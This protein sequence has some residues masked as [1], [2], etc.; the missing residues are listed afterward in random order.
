MDEAVR[1]RNDQSEST[2]FLIFMISRFLTF[3]GC[4]PKLAGS[5]ENL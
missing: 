2:I 5:A 4:V 1:V 3:T